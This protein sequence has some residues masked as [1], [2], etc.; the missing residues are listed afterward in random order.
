MCRSINVI[1]LQEMLLALVL[2]YIVRVLLPSAWPALA[3]KMQIPMLLFFVWRISSVTR[4]AILRDAI[5]Y[6]SLKTFVE[7]NL[8]S[9]QWWLQR[10]AIICLSLVAGD[11]FGGGLFV[12][13]N[14]HLAVELWRKWWE[15]KRNSIKWNGT[16]QRYIDDDSYR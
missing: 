14:R 7:T 11:R 15:R 12:G 1:V 10:R 13:R 9:E 4:K 8:Y 16:L 5:P 6:S 3:I 2:I